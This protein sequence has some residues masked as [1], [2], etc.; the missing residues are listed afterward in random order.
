MWSR[1]IVKEIVSR[2]WGFLLSTVAVAVAVGAWVMAE[3]VAASLRGRV[4]TLNEKSAGLRA[5]ADDLRGESDRI[6]G[7]TDRILAKMNQNLLIVPAGVPEDR[8]YRGDFGDQTLPDWIVQAMLD[9]H[10]VILINNL[11][12]SR[13]GDQPRI[14]IVSRDDV[15]SP[16]PPY[17]ARYLL[18]KL[19]DHYTAELQASV[20]ARAGDRSMEVFA[21]GQRHELGAK[22]DRPLSVPPKP[23]FARLGSAVAARLKLAKGDRFELAGRTLTVDSVEPEQAG[24][25]DIRVFLALSEAQDLFHQPGRINRVIALSCR[26]EGV[27]INTLADVLTKYVREWSGRYRARLLTSQPDSTGL[28]VA[29]PLEVRVTPMTRIAVARDTMRDKIESQWHAVQRQQERVAGQVDSV[30]RLHDSIRGLTRALVPVLGAIIAVLVGGYFY[31]NVRERQ[32][33]IGVLLAVGF[34]PGPITLALLV[35]LAAVSLIGGSIGVP[36]GIGLTH[37]IGRL[38]ALQLSGVAAPW[39]LWPMALAGAA[40]LTLLAGVYP[41]LLARRVQAADILRNA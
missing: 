22:S 35:K 13:R 7:E 16:L 8:Y 5:E 37:V 9:D 19:A 28:A 41:L 2:K 34:T 38:P 32:Q 17:I 27:S 33:E 23:G 3:S 12:E 1:L 10:V 31:F 21:T 24:P 29:E 25:D 26:C 39:H 15:P 36:G 18:P 6:K 4:E 30:R 20:K 11:P 14:A 40:A